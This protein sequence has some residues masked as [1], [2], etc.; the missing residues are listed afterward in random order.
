MNRSI[1]RARPFAVMAMA[2]LCGACQT[3][4]VAPPHTL[5]DDLDA[6]LNTAVSDTGSLVSEMRQLEARQSA[7]E[8]VVPATL[9]MKNAL[10]APMALNWNGS[11]ESILTF[12][13][14]S[15]KTTFVVVG[16]SGTVPMVSVKQGADGTVR[17]ALE[18]VSSQVNG[19]ADVAIV[20]GATPRL[21]LRYHK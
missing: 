12:I 4:P 14:S 10:D 18:S 16:R 13:S 6:R 2:L 15:L 11:A 3:V 21:E 9:Q 20:A 19:V 5:E 8:P 1:H 7:G 17:D